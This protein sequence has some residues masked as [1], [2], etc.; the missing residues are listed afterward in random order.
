MGLDFSAVTGSL[1]SISIWGVSIMCMLNTKV[2]PWPSPAEK[3]SMAP[4]SF[5][6]IYLQMNKPIPIPSL[7]T[8]FSVL[9]SSSLPKSE[10]IFSIFVL[11][12]PLPLSTT[13]TT[14][15]S[16]KG[17]KPALILTHYL[18]E[19]L[20]AFLVRLTSTCLRRIWSPYSLGGSESGNKQ[21]ACAYTFLA[22]EGGRRLDK[23]SK[24]SDDC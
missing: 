11:L 12:M 20:S 4:P 19:N 23:T 21:S 9:F 15:L 17:S 13:W 22:S 18:K 16:L 10:N 8:F 1:Y 24:V 7:F 3:H 2:E 14:S 6:T 5:S